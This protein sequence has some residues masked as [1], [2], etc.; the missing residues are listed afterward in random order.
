[1]FGVQTNRGLLHLSISTEK[2][3]TLMESSSTQTIWNL[4]ASLLGWGLTR[5]G[6]AYV[7]EEEDVLKAGEI[8]VTGEETF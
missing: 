5:T 7:G 6:K 4:D 3:M 2:L 1:M 8:T